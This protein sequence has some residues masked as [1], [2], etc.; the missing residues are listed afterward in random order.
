[1]DER[2]VED[3]YLSPRFET[4]RTATFSDAVI[5][6]AATLLVLELEPPE[7][8][9]SFP[10]ALLAQWPHY[11]ALASSFAVIGLIW[12]HHHRLFRLLAY[13]DH[14]MLN[15]NLLLMLAIVFVPY[16]TM[17]LAQYP[18]EDAAA[19]LYTADVA[20]IAILFNILWHSAQR[21]LREDLDPQYVRSVG[22]QYKLAAVTYVVLFAVSPF[23]IHVSIVGNILAAVFFAMPPH[24][25]RRGITAVRSAA[26]NARP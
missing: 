4:T 12:I 17:L 3:G 24:H 14:T 8:S 2:E 15:I 20:L 25:L 13:A 5:A 26:S 19:V 9:D 7:K 10:S 16:P 23:S 22:L 6:I 21:H 1:M 11:V 18:E